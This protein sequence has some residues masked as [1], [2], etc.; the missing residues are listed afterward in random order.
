MVAGTSKGLLMNEP[1]VSIIIPHYQTPELVK[2]CLR[3]IRKFTTQIPHEVIVVDNAS[4]DGASL[5]YLRGVEWIRLIE[6]HENVARGGAGHREAVEIGFGA[7]RAPYLLTIHT[8]TIPIRN[9]WLE[10]HL[11]PLL[12]D[13]AV[14]ATGTDKLNLRPRYREWLRGL[15]DWA[16]WWKRSRT[17]RL[18]NSKPFIR[19]HCALYRRSILEKHNIRY[20]DAPS[21]TAGR[22]MYQELIRLGY[23]C[24]LLDP[25][26]VVQRVVHLEHATMLLVP[27]FRSTLRKLLVYRGLRRI[28]RFLN[29][30]EIRQLM[31]DDSLDL[32][33]SHW[34]RSA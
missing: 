14:A 18:F 7:A 20:N 16:M 22:G 32:A 31:A 28:R 26:D 34:K 29:Q 6:R 4:R 12:D 8:D 1:L 5:D 2:L 9:D 11:Q 30:S 15:E 27:E 13:E 17:V 10:Y 24:P 19:S 25:R 21:L 3:S 23:E 33:D